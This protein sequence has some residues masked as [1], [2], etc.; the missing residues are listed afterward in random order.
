VAALF[1]ALPHVPQ[2]GVALVVRSHGIASVLAAVAATTGGQSSF[3]T[4]Q[5]YSLRGSAIAPAIPH[6]VL[7]AALLGRA[8]HGHQAPEPL[9]CDIC[10]KK[11]LH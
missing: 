6:D 2:L 5:C 1:H 7:A 4:A 9:T 11:I 3:K 10:H 8:V